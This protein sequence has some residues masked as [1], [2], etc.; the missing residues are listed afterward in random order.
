MRTRRGRGGAKTGARDTKVCHDKL[1][2]WATDECHR[3]IGPVAALRFSNTGVHAELAFGEHHENR[4]E[5]IFKLLTQG[6]DAA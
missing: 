1:T 4:Q 5:S 6:M 2:E 3:V